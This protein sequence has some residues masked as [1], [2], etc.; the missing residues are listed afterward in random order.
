MSNIGWYRYKVSD[1]AEGEQTIKFFINGALAKTCT[2]IGKPFCSDF[3]LIKY[4]NKNG[5]YR[6]FPFNKYW[7]QANKPTLIG[8]VNSFVTNILDNQGDKKNIGYANERK[9]ILVAESVSLE[10]LEILEDI[11]ISPR[12]YLYVGNGLNDRLRDWVLVSIT[13]DG[14]GKPKKANFKKVTI[15]VTLPEYYAITK[16]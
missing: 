8:K 16:V 2:V 6:F 5:Q 13:G 9:I 11:Y 1:S 7:Q 12:V 4:L 14:I 10:E 3:R 15:E